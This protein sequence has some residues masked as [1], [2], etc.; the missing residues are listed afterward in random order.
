MFQLDLKVI[1]GDTFRRTFRFL[2][3]A[4]NTP[5]DLSSWTWDAQIRIDPDDVEPLAAFTVDTTQVSLGYLTL[6]LASS[7]TEDLVTSFWDL[8]GTREGEVVTKGGGRVVVKKDV[9]R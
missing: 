3:K 2:D 1:R 7:V 5:K 9:T 6:S 8:Q 4:T